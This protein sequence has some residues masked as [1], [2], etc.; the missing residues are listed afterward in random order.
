MLYFMYVI[1]LTTNCTVFITTNY[2]Y[3]ELFIA[4]FLKRFGVS[5]LKMETM[6]KHVKLST[7]KIHR[8]RNGTFI[9]VTKVVMY[10]NAWNE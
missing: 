10:H 2:I 1:C 9:G 5:F 8:F 4:M 7:S 6:L 3:C